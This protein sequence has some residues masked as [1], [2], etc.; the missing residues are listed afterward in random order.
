M[1]LNKK[2]VLIE[3][4]ADK[5]QDDHGIYLQ[6]EWVKPMPTGKVV[7][8]ADDV[9]FCKAGDRVFFERYTSI[10]DPENETYRYCRED[11]VIAVYEKD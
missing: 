11:A 5:T 6:D 10:Q 3:V 2:L 9:K 7:A 1:K 8:V 4:D